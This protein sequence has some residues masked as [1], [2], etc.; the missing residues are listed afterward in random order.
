MKKSFKLKMLIPN[1]SMLHAVL[2]RNGQFSLFQ[3][4][5]S[6]MELPRD[7]VT[8]SHPVPRQYHS[9]RGVGNDQHMI[10]MRFGNYQNQSVESIEDVISAKNPASIK[11]INLSFFSKSILKH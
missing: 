9:R 7:A 5:M 11:H 6:H 8:I 10:K 3:F 4:H 2:W 1:L